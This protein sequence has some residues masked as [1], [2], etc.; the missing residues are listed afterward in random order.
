[1]KLYWVTIELSGAVYAENLREALDVASQ[2]FRHGDVEEYQDAK[3]IKELYQIP[4]SWRNALPFVPDYVD[5]ELTCK[6]I[7][8]TPDSDWRNEHHDDSQLALDITN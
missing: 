6:Q 7:L 2:E 4:K 1:M 3:E 5:E 8:E